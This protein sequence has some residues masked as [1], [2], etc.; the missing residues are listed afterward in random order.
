MFSAVVH[1]EGL[2]LSSASSTETKWFGCHGDVCRV[3]CAGALE[4]QRRKYEQ[5]LAELKSQLVEDRTV[6]SPALSEKLQSYQAEEEGEEMLYINQERL[7]DSFVRTNSLVSEAN[8][9]SEELHRDMFFRVTLQIPAKFLTPHK[10][11]GC[12][13]FLPLEVHRSTG[14]TFCRTSITTLVMRSWLGYSTSTSAQ[15]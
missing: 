8:M 9:L 4:E 11:V 12:W 5:Q 10:E 13:P 14:P 15:I 2:L 6:S 7:L 1:W 3:C